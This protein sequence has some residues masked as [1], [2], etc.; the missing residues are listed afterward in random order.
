MEMFKSWR[1]KSWNKWTL[2]P[3]R[4]ITGFGFMAHGYAKLSRGPEG[5]ARILQTIGVP[6]PSLA[7]WMTALV[8][9]FGGLV[10][11]AGAFVAIA[12]IPLIIVMLVAMF[13]VHLPYGFSAIKLMVMTASGPQF[14][15]P[16]YEVNFLYIAGLLTLILGGAGPLSIDNMLVQ[17]KDVS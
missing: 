10:I 14:G 5:F 15:T 17:R 16:G 6:A 7:A 8:E 3:L 11:I 1:E 12:S 4:L 9:F 2:L 13:T